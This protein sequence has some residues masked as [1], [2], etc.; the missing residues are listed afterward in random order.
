MATMPTST[1][2]DTGSATT[3]TCHSRYSVLNCHNLSA[4]NWSLPVMSS[5]CRRDG[6]CWE[7]KSS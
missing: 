3:R 2:V 5:S 7:R 4:E 6:K 1:M